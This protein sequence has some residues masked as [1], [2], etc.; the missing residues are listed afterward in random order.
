MSLQDL[1]KSAFIGAIQGIYSGADL[2]LQAL[3]PGV[4]NV[5]ARSVFLRANKFM[6]EVKGRHD[7][8]SFKADNGATI[9][10]FGQLDVKKAGA[11]NKLFA[12]IL[13]AVNLI[14]LIEQHNAHRADRRLHKSGALHGFQARNDGF[15]PLAD[16]LILFDERSAFCQ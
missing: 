1:K 7:S 2:V 6:G 4:D 15:N 14:V 3:Q 12:L 13:L 10:Y 5:A 9:F 16:Y 8:D 11:L